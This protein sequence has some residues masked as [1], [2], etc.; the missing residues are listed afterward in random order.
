MTT[1]DDLYK[2]FD[3]L[4]THDYSNDGFLIITRDNNIDISVIVSD[5]FYWGTAD[6][7]E[8]EVTDI[9]DLEQAYQ[10]MGKVEK[11]TNNEVLWLWACRKRKM[12]PMDGCYDLIPESLH[13]LFN[14][15]GPKRE[16]DSLNCPRKTTNT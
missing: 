2:V 3:W 10:D 8:I 6:G 4:W 7:E 14:A 5:F 15:A 1:F 13:E 16:M 9:P 11:Y 12:R